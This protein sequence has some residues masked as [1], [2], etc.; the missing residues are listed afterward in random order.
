MLVQKELYRSVIFYILITF[1]CYRPKNTKC[2]KIWFGLL[3]L[4]PC[5]LL[6]F[7]KSSDCPLHTNSRRQHIKSYKHINWAMHLQ[8]IGQLRLSSRCQHE[9]NYHKLTPLY[10]SELQPNT[11]ITYLVKI[12]R[13]HSE[14]IKTI[15]FPQLFFPCQ[16]FVNPFSL[17]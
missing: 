3:P 17:F 1:A 13:Q 8:P 9:Y 10:L 14:I 7:F 16:P 12:N 15:Y 4:S 11:F 2:Q 6:Y 5:F